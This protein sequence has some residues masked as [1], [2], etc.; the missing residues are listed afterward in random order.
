VSRTPPVLLVCVLLQENASACEFEDST[1][2][3][4]LAADAHE[5]TMSPSEPLEPSLRRAFVSFDELPMPHEEREDQDHE[6]D[7][8]EQQDP[9]SEKQEKKRKKRNATRPE[10]KGKGRLFGRDWHP[11]ED[12]L[13]LRALCEFFCDVD[14][15][16]WRLMQV[17]YFGD[18]SPFP[19]GVDEM[20]NRERRI[21][22][23]AK[24][25]FDPKS[26]PTRCG[27][28]GCNQ[29]KKG[30]ICLN[31][32]GKFMSKEVRKKAAAEANALLV[33]GAR[34]GM[35]DY[36]E[37]LNALE[38]GAS[39]GAS[40]QCPMEAPVKADDQKED[41]PK[42]DGNPDDVPLPDELAMP[43]LVPVPVVLTQQLLVM[44]TP[45]RMPIALASPLLDPIQPVQCI[46]PLTA[47]FE[48]E[49]PPLCTV[50][51][52][53]A[54][55]D[56][57]VS[58]GPPPAESGIAKG[59]F[60]KI[61]KGDLAEPGIAEPGIAEPDIAEPDIAEPDIAA[62]GMVWSIAD[63][64]RAL[65]EDAIRLAK[66]ELFAEL[67]A[68]SPAPTTKREIP[69]PAPVTGEVHGSR[70]LPSSVPEKLPRAE[71]MCEPRERAPLLRAAVD[72]ELYDRAPPLPRTLNMGMGMASAPTASSL[73]FF[74]V[75]EGSQFDDDDVQSSA[76]LADDLWSFGG[77]QEHD[78]A[79][80]V[81]QWAFEAAAEDSPPKRHKREKLEHAR[82]C[83]E[84]VSARVAPPIDRFVSYE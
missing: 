27:K 69:T 23:A 22:Q 53:P 66:E 10:N 48:H 32:D 41:G 34:I 17:K 74:A 49:M 55:I 3:E 46:S 76:P 57:A 20:R 79:M 31:P 70:K 58:H 54:I 7:E 77:A 47:S 13:L 67:T 61:A 35:A 50:A 16:P 84:R 26:P 40:G 62:S 42:D 72:S 6:V 43:A 44:Q 12:K 73:R 18:D 71:T 19:R 81:A 51:A 11:D 21:R 65:R 25:V 64:E 80:Q 45:A 56:P 59:G 37:M 33:P 75:V 29:P 2:A 9:G 68:P 8:E 82:S 83:P 38:M 14:K 15:R 28:E 63:V 36:A 39:D 30:H 60:A 5:P 4:R 24:E 1:E 52:L 78:V